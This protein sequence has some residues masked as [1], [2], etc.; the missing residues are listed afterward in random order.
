M[1]I[2]PETCPYLDQCCG[3]HGQCVKCTGGKEND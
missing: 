1:T 2:T 3:C